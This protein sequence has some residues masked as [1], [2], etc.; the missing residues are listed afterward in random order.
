MKK[1][2][3]RWV[4][5][6]L[7][8]MALATGA[9]AL[10]VNS[11]SSNG[12]ARAYG[13]V[14]AQDRSLDRVAAQFPELQRDVELTRLEFS[15]RFPRMK[16]KLEQTLRGAMPAPEWKSFEAKMSERITAQDRPVSQVE[17]QQF[18]Q[19]V[20]ERAKGDIDAT[21]LGYMLAVQYETNP[22]A[23]M[24]NGFKQPYQTK[25]AGKAKGVQVNMQLPRSWL[26]AEGNR[27]NIVQKWVSE[28]GTGGETVMLLINDTDGPDPTKADIAAFLKDGGAN[29]IVPEGGKLLSSRAVTIERQPGY[30][31]EF[32]LDQ[33]RAGLALT[34][35]MAMYL[36][37]YRG[38]AIGLQCTAGAPIEKRAA[39]A[40]AFDRVR[41]LCQQVAN[42]IVFPQKY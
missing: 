22:S 26:A 42:S 3:F 36:V 31:V 10:N 7:L 25:G 12:I 28:N 18:L 20:R 32:D 11:V 4:A 2:V 19:L 5:T 13:F 40:K 35:R 29:D 24:A 37:F 6:V 27:P 38:K 41:P 33:E 30:L 8:S 39:V 1:R 16:E 17:A 15:A 34:T 14:W 9:L 21:V 23:E